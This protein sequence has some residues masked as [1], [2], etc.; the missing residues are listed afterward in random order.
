[1]QLAP[2]VYINM[3]PTCQAPIFEADSA[4]GLWKTLHILKASDLISVILLIKAHKAASGNTDE[5]KNT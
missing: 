5:N 3:I 1:M 4:K 2:Q